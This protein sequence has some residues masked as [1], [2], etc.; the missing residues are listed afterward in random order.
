MER[1]G[2]TNPELVETKNNLTELVDAF[3]TLDQQFLVKQSEFVQQEMALEDAN[4]RIAEAI[5]HSEQL[6]HN[7]NATLDQLHQG[8]GNAKLVNR[9]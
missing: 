8:I 5:K 3:T 6:L 4:T 9:F 2:A 7:P 1:E